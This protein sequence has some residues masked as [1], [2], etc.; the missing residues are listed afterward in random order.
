MST[1]PAGFAFQ[2]SHG[3]YPKKVAETGGDKTYS[4]G[5]LVC[6]QTV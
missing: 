5:E 6:A 4:E 2:C 3:I 1:L